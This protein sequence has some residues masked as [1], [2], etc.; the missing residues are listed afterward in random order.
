MDLGPFI[1]ILPYLSDTY[2]VGSKEN[3]CVYFVSVLLRL[4]YGTLASPKR[5]IARPP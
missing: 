4:N 5:T 2:T 1:F 3:A